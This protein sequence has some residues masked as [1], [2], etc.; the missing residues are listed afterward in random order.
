MT[1]S[2]HGH[3]E[4]PHSIKP[5]K[6][7]HTL[8]GDKGQIGSS[9]KNDNLCRSHPGDKSM[10][11]L[12]YRVL[13]RLTSEPQQGLTKSGNCFLRLPRNACWF[14]PSPG[15]MAVPFLPHCLSRSSYSPRAQQ[16]T[17][18]ASK[19]DRMEQTIYFGHSAKLRVFIQKQILS[20]VSTL[21]L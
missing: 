20:L 4:T 16:H 11:S 21:Q 1:H 14:I 8:W 18:R 3:G 2:H 12:V 10:V 9:T 13:P 5:L 6:A 17:P 19:P 7:G 15:H